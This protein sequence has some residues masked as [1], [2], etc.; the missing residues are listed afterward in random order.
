VLD[1]LHRP[2]EF[3]SFPGALPHKPGTARKLA[4]LELDPPLHTAF[5]HAEA[6]LFSP[7]A[8]DALEPM[9]VEA[10]VELVKDLSGRGSCDGMDDFARPVTLTILGRMLGIRQ[11][12]LLEFHDWVLEMN[13]APPGHPQNIEGT[14]KISSYLYDLIRER[15]HDAGDDVISGLWRRPIGDRPA[16]ADDVFDQVLLLL[17]AGL[18]TT[19]SALGFQLHYLATHPEEQRR[20]AEDPTLVPAALEEMLRAFPP[21]NSIRTANDDVEVAGVEMRAGDHILVCWTLVNRDPDLAPAPHTVVLDRQPNRHYAFGAGP[22]RCVGLHLARRELR[23][24]LE[25]WHRTIPP[26]RL[27]DGAELASHGGPTMILRNLPLVWD[28]GDVPAARETGA[29]GVEPNRVRG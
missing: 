23:I 3:T 12:D 11:Q 2:G 26:Y 9:I 22:H 28:A 1:V 27:A 13:S 19:A 24:A 5:R 15:Q 17:L 8:I 6:P 16:N 14:R 10:T 7:H 4:P 29:E 21:P 20:L 25:E 18:D